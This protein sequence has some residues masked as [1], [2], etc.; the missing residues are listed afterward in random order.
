MAEVKE[1]SSKLGAEEIEQFALDT[2]QEMFALFSRDTGHKYKAK[3]RSLTFNIKDRKNETLFQKICERAVKPY[4]L[5]RMS[6]EELASQELA[7]WRENENK[8]QL[9]MI[10][11]SEMD[12]LACAKSYVLKSHK[13]EEVMENMNA[14]NQIEAVDDL[15]MLSSELGVKE[16]ERSNS[17]SLESRSKDK[18]RERSRERD[19]DKHRS[20]HSSSKHKRKRSRE[21]S[22]DRERDRDRTKD[23]EREK[24]TSGSGGGGGNSSSSKHKSSHHSSSSSHHHHVSGSGSKEKTSISSSS[25]S[26]KDSS[27]RHRDKVHTIK[28]ESNHSSSP[29]S[30]TSSSNNKS[31]ASGGEAQIFRPSKKETEESYDLIEKILQGTS[32][33]LVAKLHELEKQKSMVEVKQEKGGEGEPTANEGG[34]TSED[35]EYNPESANPEREDTPPAPLPPTPLHPR[36]IWNGKVVYQ[37]FHFNGCIVPVYG[38]TSDVLPDFPAVFDVPGRIGPEVV[39]D[40]LGKIKRSVNRDITVVRFL[41]RS[42][43]DQEDYD[44][45][46]SYFESKGRLGVLKPKS[47]VIKDFYL[48]PQRKGKLLPSVLLTLKGLGDFETKANCIVGI[49]VK[50]TLKR[51]S[52]SMGGGSGASASKMVKKSQ[53]SGIREE[54]HQTPPGSPKVPPHKLTMGLPKVPMLAT[55][56]GEREERESDG[57]VLILLPSTDD[58][59]PY[60]PGGSEEEDSAQDSIPAAPPAPTIVSSE[61]QK[62]VDRL[63]RQIEAEKNEIVDMLAKDPLVS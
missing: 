39:W 59:E 40:Y 58:D 34:T 2:E 37:E 35:V 9:D 29:A 8:H 50:A 5:V 31:S 3:Y 32:P 20:H 57:Q 23:K 43:K 56:T 48:V 45:M 55:K 28:E 47:D 24:G 30:N 53:V 22:R 1:G 27:S 49:V 60:S 16:E 51:P 36:A 7:K 46:Y 11:K 61:L 38:D 52:S 10:K 15:T 41:P 4:R 33:E 21:R 18:K 19:R 17:K 6:P 44:S 26:K 13:G 54:A 12:L 25:G 42:P 63:N 62:E 14:D